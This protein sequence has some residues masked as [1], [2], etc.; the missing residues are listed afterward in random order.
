MVFAFPFT[1]VHRDISQD[2][3]VLLIT[4]GIH[5]DEPAAFLA[6]GMLINN[7][8]ITSGRI[9]IVPNLNFQSIL[10]TSRGIAGDMNRKFL[11][12]TKNDPDYVNLEAIKKLIT[13]P[14]VDFVYSMHDGSGFYREKHLS[15][16][17]S[18]YRWGQ[19]IVI[20]QETLDPSIPHYNLHELGSK[21]VSN[22]NEKLI[23]KN[24]QYRVR[25]TK[26][27]EGNNPMEQSLTWFSVQH[28]KASIGVEASKN[29]PLSRGI[30]YHLIALETLLKER[31]ITFERNFE[32]SPQGVHKALYDVDLT[33]FD[34]YK[35][36]IRNIRKSLRFVPFPS[37]EVKFTTSN[38]LLYVYRKKN[39][40]VVQ[41]GNTI[42]T[43]LHPELIRFDPSLSSLHILIDGKSADIPM[44]TVFDVQKNFSVPV[45]KGYRLNVIGYVH[46]TKK[47]E[48]DCLITRKN[49]SSQYSIDTT[50]QTYRVEIYKNDAFVGLVYARFPLKNTKTI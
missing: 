19:C 14:D 13:H 47:N 31:G 23:A 48:F 46:P 2:G 11:G 39:A 4:A 15:T 24:E 25:N 21:I 34:S 43:T 37:A 20:D 28:G 10:H 1:T 27:K 36:P 29:I 33:L 38:P 5:G 9:W 26:T 8:T 3:P 30:Y 12:T 6:A 42:L 49:I 7:Y 35:L 22:L 32:L 44:G 45:L 50:K 40:Y 41:Y 18:P 16:L 17:Y